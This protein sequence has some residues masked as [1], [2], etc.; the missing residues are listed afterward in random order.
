MR[1]FAGVLLTFI[2]MHLIVIA[3]KMSIGGYLALNSFS[4]W[5]YYFAPLALG[6]LIVVTGVRVVR[7]AARE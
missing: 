7:H 5:A 4:T 6:T 3:V 2:G 1:I